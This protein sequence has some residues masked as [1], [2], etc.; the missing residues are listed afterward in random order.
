[1]R[2]GGVR[3]A[4]ITHKLVKGDGQGRVNYELAL[5]ALAAG[6]CVWLL[7][8]EVAPELAAHPRARWVRVGAPWL[9]SAL[10]QNQAFAWKSTAWLWRH[11]SELDLVHANGFVSW[12]AADIN[13]SHFVHSAWLRS[14]FHT[15]RV[16]RDAY[17]L[18]QLLY[19]YCGTWLE[20]WSYRRARLVA[21]VSEQVR[22]ELVESGVAP[23][24]LTV[25]ANGV[26]TEEFKPGEVSRAT[27]G[28]PAGRLL[29]FVG[30]I[31]TPRKNLDTLLRAL[32]EVRDAN[33]VVVGDRTGSPYPR[34]A[35][36][37]G[38]EERVSFVGFRRDI[39]RLMQAVDLFVF[40][41]RYEACSLVLL[42]AAAS[43][44]PIVAARTTGGAEL[45]SPS[46]SMLVDDPEDAAALAA[47]LNRLL[48]SPAALE[49]MGIEARRVALA[50][51]WQTM[52]RRYLQLYDGLLENHDPTRNADA[53]PRERSNGVERVEVRSEAHD[54]AGR[55]ARVAQEAIAAHPQGQRRA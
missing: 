46:C 3:L 51:S 4:L 23:A 52:A 48:E 9:P 21:A 10:L 12:A 15:W 30:D 2:S 20:R 25:V 32:V 18:Y 1:L 13:T 38:L 7:A 47:T 33:L 37:L 36:E 14:P 55:D 29:L 44:L 41:S 24:R 11:R 5:A 22:R 35:A 54:A 42:E 40:P 27:L 45:L 39:P 50:N 8:S 6:H 19:S 31:R 28:L 49:H 17:G 34:L 53:T 16:R 43:G 26:D